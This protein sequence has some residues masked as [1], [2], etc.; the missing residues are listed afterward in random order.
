[1]P[2]GI[3]EVTVRISDRKEVARFIKAVRDV[4]SIQQDGHFCT[5]GYRQGGPMITRHGKAC[6]ELD[7]ALKDMVNA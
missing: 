6:V 2:V 3:A 1:M 4:G 5:C 7:A